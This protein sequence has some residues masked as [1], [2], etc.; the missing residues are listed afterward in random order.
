M[1]ATI[2]IFPRT[3][4][5]YDGCDLRVQAPA[6]ATLL[7]QLAADAAAGRRRRSKLP[8]AGCSRDF[9][10]FDLDEREQSRCSRSGRRATRCAS[11]FGRESLIFSPGEKFDL[12]VQ[13]HQLDLTP[14]T[15]YLLSASLGPARGDEQTWTEDREIR[16]DAGRRRPGRGAVDS[17]AR[18]EG[19]YD[20]RL[21]LY[22]KRLTATPLV[23]GKPLAYRAR[24]SSSC[25]RR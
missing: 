25:C 24:C 3:P 9:A 19:V 12:E 6:D 17:P 10:Q 8:L 4:R 16:V 14:G 22:P 20:V 2:R 18:A 21:S 13:P 7:V 5:S 1:R 11:N 15:S 23:R